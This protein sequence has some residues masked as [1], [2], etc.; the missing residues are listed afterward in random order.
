MKDKKTLKF[1]ALLNA[2]KQICVIAFPMITFP[3]AS[4]VLG[5]DNYGKI[6]FGA[7]IISY[8]SS[9]AVLGIFNYAI[10][11]GAKKANKKKEFFPFVDEIFSLNI[12]SMVFAEAIL[13]LLIIFWP[14]LNSYVPIIWIQNL[15]VIF[16]TIG[17]DWINTIFEDYLYMTVRYIGCQT[18]AIILM[19]VLVKEPEDYIW[20]A[21]T[22]IFATVLANVLNMAYI[23]INYKIYPKVIFK[24]SVFK[25]LKSVMILFGSSVATLIYINSDITLLGILGNDR[26]VGYYSIS[27]KIYKLVKQFINAILVVSIPRIS[28]YISDGNREKIDGIFQNTYEMLIILIAPAASGL[29]FLS[30]SIIV[31]FSGYEYLKSSD[32][33]IILSIALLFATLACFYVSL[34]MLPYRMDKEILIATIVSAVANIGLNIVLIPVFL[35]KAAALTTL[36]S[37][38][39]MVVFGIYHSYKKMHLKR[40]KVLCVGVCE[41]LGVGIICSMIL[42]VQ[43]NDYLIIIFS[44]ILS[45]LY[46]LS[47]V[48]LVYRK[49]I[50]DML[51]KAKKKY[52]KI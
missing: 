6:N 51:E 44:I 2:L 21:F 28:K 39:I 30:R 26:V 42:K 34:V 35:E 16:T 41:A 7:S 47:V 18:L 3:Y 50:I 46:C 52:D 48:G 37:E 20:Y 40:A 27:S 13:V 22:N 1:N 32:S 8:I 23:R 15:V 4:R 14:K 29:L 31:S 12:F 17:T 11:E 9:I 10:T 45:M 33:L 25:H 49:R 24:K 36:L 5:A 38:S 19:F 43:E